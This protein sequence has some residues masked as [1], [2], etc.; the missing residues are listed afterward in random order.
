[1]LTQEQRLKLKSAGYSDTKI[2]VFEAQKAIKDNESKP[3]EP[4]FAGKV[5]R[6]TVRPLANVAT[7]IVKAGDVATGGTGEVEPFSGKYL[8]EVKGL[9]KLDLT[10]GITPENIKVLKDSVK[11]GVDIGVLLGGGAGVGTV[12]KTGIKKGIIQG[13]KVGAKSGSV[14]GAISGAGTGLEEDATVGSTAKNIALGAGTGA[15]VGGA[16]GGVSSGIS[17][18]VSSIK[19]IPET[20]KNIANKILGK[21]S[22]EK[23]FAL[24]LV[25]PKATEKIKQQAI[26][27]G[28]VTEQGL[29]RPSKILPSKRDVVLANTIKG[30]VSM[31]NTPV[32]NVS[33]LDNKISKINNNVKSYVSKNKVPFNT[34]QLKTQLNKGKSELKLIF[35]SDK[36]TEKTY[37]V[38]VNE[39]INHVKSKDT[40]GLLD[41]RQAVDKIPAIKKL[42]ESQGLGENSKKE[43][44]L[45]LRRQANK[46]ISNL[47]PKDNKYRTDLLKE[48]QMLEVIFNMAMK[49]SKEIGMNKIQSLTAKYPLLKWA[50]GGLVGAG[51]VGVGGAIIGS[52]D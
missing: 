37:N 51:G 3:Q 5:I 48:S 25:S 27:E 20:G 8:G 21:P 34:N 36:Q 6:E 29:I 52:L 13:A 41:A 22:N 31:K 23:Q 50:V 7:N 17:N 1:M 38:L 35:A 15:V 45:T 40:A 33:A 2:N 47:L 14:V 39:F 12:A 42:L 16:V 43:I 28:R 44:V 11:A 49:N 24:D 19:K 26:S 30:V 10:K 4:T 9:G 46:Y 18:T 32:Q